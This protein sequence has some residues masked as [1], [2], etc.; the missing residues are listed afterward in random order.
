MPSI[1]PRKDTIPLSCNKCNTGNKDHSL[2][3]LLCFAYLNLTVSSMS[4]I[5]RAYIQ[6]DMSF[7][8]VIVVGYLPILCWTIVY[9]LNDDK[10]SFRVSCPAD[11]VSGKEN[12]NIIPVS[13]IV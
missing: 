5:Y 7:I 10:K 2:G 8:L 11:R 4:T 9:F 12:K 6:N 13:E 1:H 3:L